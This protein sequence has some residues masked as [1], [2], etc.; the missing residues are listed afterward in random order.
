MAGAFAQVAVKGLAV[1]V[2]GADEAGKVAGEAA[3]AADGLG[4]ACGRAGAAHTH[5]KRVRHLD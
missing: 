5:A 1:V 4:A 3:D 2:D